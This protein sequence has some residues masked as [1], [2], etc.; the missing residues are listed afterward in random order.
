MAA[1]ALQRGVGERTNTG[2]LV[3]VHGFD[4]V[5]TIVDHLDAE[6]LRPLP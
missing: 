6:W 3:D 4:D 1:K 5:A 2:D